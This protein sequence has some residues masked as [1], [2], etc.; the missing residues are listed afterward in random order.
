MPI[1]V[2]NSTRLYECP[3]CGFQHTSTTP[4]RQTPTHVCPRQRGLSVPLVAVLNGDSLPSGS[5]RHV[6]VERQDFIGNERGVTHD[7]TG[8]AVMAVRTERADGSNDC[9]IFAP[10]AQSATS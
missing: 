10:I 1:P 2:L 8:R 4:G 9:R 3:S 6:A 7:D 5:A